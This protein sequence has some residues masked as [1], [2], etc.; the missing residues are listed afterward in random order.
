MKKREK[1]NVER[2]VTALRTTFARMK[3]KYVYQREGNVEGRKRKRAAA[4]R[5]K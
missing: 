2:E 4:R 1:K 3:M 5:D